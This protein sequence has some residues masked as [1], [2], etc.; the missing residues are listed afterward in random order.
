MTSSFTA[1]LIAL[2]LLAV[3]ALTGVYDL[4]RLRA[5][6]A[7]LLER[8]QAQVR[9]LAET[10]AAAARPLLARRRM[11][12][13][14]VLVDRVAAFPEISR[15]TI[16]DADQDMVATALAPG[17]PE[18]D[19]EG[20]LLA[21]AAE[22]GEPLGEFT[23]EGAAQVYQYVLPLAGRRR[24]GYIE[25]VYPW[26]PVEGQI[27]ERQ[28][29]ILIT[30]GA[31][32]L[33]MG[34]AFWV[35][36][37]FHVGRPLRR[38]VDAMEAVGAG[39]LG[40]RVDLPRRDEIGRLAAQFNWMGDRLQEAR[41]EL[42]RE[43]ERKVDMERQIRRQEKLAALGKVSS[44]LAHEI[45]TPLNIIAG[46]AEHLQSRMDPGD[47]RAR[48]LRTITAQIER[49][50]ETVK[51]VLAFARS[52]EPRRQLLPLAEVVRTVAEFLHRE[53]TAQG[54][55][56]DLAVDEAPKAS[57]DPDQLQQ[58]L[59][60]VLVNALEA[61]ARGGTIRVEAAADPA[62]PT[63][64]VI[65]VA[66]TGKGIAPEV[67]PRVFEPFVTTKGSGRGTGLG[68]A[69]SRDLVRAHG[70]DMAIASEPGRGTT[71]TIRLPLEPPA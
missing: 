20:E 68:L 28:R 3:V 9:M 33:G 36:M 16:Y 26:A 13:V 14:R 67:L 5:Q 6:R 37:R 8:M 29:G 47:P 18:G 65:A 52:P 12:E 44:E 10:L 49:I 23:G 63:W 66:D 45:G 24:A 1:R 43:A 53:A 30:R 42:L 70:G 25:I 48:D 31:I 61:T 2:L 55:G 62:D 57:V 56:V 17:A 21:R 4:Q 40:S 50:T 34:L 15:V 38:L 51:R 7:Q 27:Q 58:V 60:N 39:N 11:D 32:L 71:V 22:R 19:T 35:I 69:I 41:N 54:V 64:A 59:L 46:R